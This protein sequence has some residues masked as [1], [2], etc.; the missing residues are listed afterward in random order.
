MIINKVPRLRIEG[1][2]LRVLRLGAL[3]IAEISFLCSVDKNWCIMD[4][5]TAIV[6]ADTI[7]QYNRFF[8]FETRHTLVGIV[9]RRVR[10]AANAP[11]DAGDFMPFSQEDDRVCV[12]NYGKTI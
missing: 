6:K 11:D 12:I 5:H 4:N 8:G 2:Q 9:H 3:D 10:A 1:P 7:E